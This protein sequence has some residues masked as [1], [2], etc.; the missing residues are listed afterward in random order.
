[1]GLQ[2]ERGKVLSIQQ[3]RRQGFQVSLTSAAAA[4]DSSAKL[5]HDV[6]RLFEAASAAD[7]VAVS[8]RATP[9]Q[10]RVIVSRRMKRHSRLGEF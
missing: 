4:S 2:K 1:M 5:A 10:R 9:V 3:Q 7:D 8:W 6:T